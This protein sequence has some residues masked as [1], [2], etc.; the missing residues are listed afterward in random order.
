MNNEALKITHLESVKEMS[1]QEIN[2]LREILLTDPIKINSA[3]D[4][5]TKRKQKATG[6]EAER[7]EKNIQNL[8]LILEEVVNTTM[9]IY[10]I[11][12][13]EEP[14]KEE[15][16]DETEQIE[17]QPEQITMVHQPPVEE[18][19]VET[20]VV[21]D[22]DKSTTALRVVRD[23]DEL[24]EKYKDIIKKYRMDA[25]VEYLK[26][27][28][29]ET[30]IEVAHF[31]LGNGLYEASNPKKWDDKKINGWLN[32]TVFKEKK[33]K[34]EKVEEPA[35]EPETLE[36]KYKD[37]VNNLTLSQVGERIQQL[38]AEDKGMEAVEFATYILINKLYVKS[39]QEPMDWTNET[40]AVYIEQV[41]NGMSS[42]VVIPEAEEVPFWDITY[43]EV[44]SKI[45]EASTKEDATIDSLKALF[46]DILNEN[47]GK[48]I[49][50]IDDLIKESNAEQV[51]N[52]LFNST[53]TYRLNE[54]K[55][56]KQQEQFEKDHAQMKEE[57][58]EEFAKTYIAPNKEKF[59]NGELKPAADGV[60]PL[61]KHLVEKGF[62]LT[63]LQTAKDHFMDLARRAAVNVKW[64]GK[65]IEKTEPIPLP[66]T[67][68]TQA[69]EPVAIIGPEVAVNNNYPE[70]KEEVEKARYLEDMYFISRKYTDADKKATALQLITNAFTE[71]KVYEKSDSEQPLDWTLEQIDSWLQTE[72]QVEPK[73]DQPLVDAETDISKEPEEVI[74]EPKTDKTANPFFK[75]KKK[76]QF[77]AAV[78]DSAIYLK[79]ENKDIKEIRST[80]AHM[81]MDARKEK[82]SFA[83][84]A[85]KGANEG[86]LYQAINKI[87]INANVDGFMNN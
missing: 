47:T 48:S 85:Y 40:V 79:S 2:V 82:H 63:T 35:K 60:I 39:D 50:R 84:S 28:T 22:S 56:K 64:L 77:I 73:T 65:P 12:K 17:S 52:D 18:A 42:E 75:A 25:F 66:E 55:A 34:S 27:L 68:E 11:S 10:N 80:I 49:E 9:K 26:T 76:D 61:K 24:R 19:K 87:C 32:T 59:E 83:R 81:I 86:E 1:N 44:Y 70:I 58:L 8:Y 16:K 46:M 21:E 23:D 74:E 71:K 51:W 57:V 37:Y 4:I 72:M 14:S 30:A 13:P 62:T 15:V 45:Q 36:D 6:E 41:T 38:V 5:W 7:C 3:I 69:P 33:Q 54:V 31:I 43:N 20:E 67:T 78:V 29:K 53:F